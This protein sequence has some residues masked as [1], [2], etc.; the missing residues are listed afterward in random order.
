MY[1][2]RHKQDLDKRALNFLSSI[3]IDDKILYYDIW[4]TKAHV[5]MLHDIRL[6]SKDELVEI[7]NELD[8]ILRH[9]AKLAKE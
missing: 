7:V 2:S 8:R 9:P 6:L 4:C 5:I 3:D 1:R